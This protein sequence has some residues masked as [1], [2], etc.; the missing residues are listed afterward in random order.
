MVIRSKTQFTLNF[1]LKDWL[2]STEMI[3]FVKFDLQ[4]LP[5]K[6]L[7]AMNGMLLEN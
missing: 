1:E 7:I 2:V 5:L 3:N 6:F 4:I